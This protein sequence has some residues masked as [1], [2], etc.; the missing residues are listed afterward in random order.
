M[1]VLDN[2]QDQNGNPTPRTALF[3]TALL[4]LGTAVAAIQAAPSADADL[5]RQFTQTVRPFLDSYCTSCH[6]GAKWTKSRTKGLYQDNPLLQVDP[7]GPAFFTGVG[8]NDAGVA[9]AGPQVVS[10]TRD[11]KGTLLMLDNVGTF[12]AASPIEIRGAGAVAGQSTLGFGAFGLGGF[13]SPS[14]LGVA[15]SAPYFHDGSS[16]T[17]ED[18]AARHKLGTGT[19]ASSLSAADLADLLSFVK[20]IDDAT[21]TMPNATDAFIQP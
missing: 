4:I 20:S 13:N 19:I 11:V 2:R 5:E 21:T 17:L 12:N 1:F 18:V 10:V 3:A 6:G 8:K 14:L 16:N 9:L 7:I 15:Y